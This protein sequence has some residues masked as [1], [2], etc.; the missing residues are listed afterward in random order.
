[1]KKNV[2]SVND[3]Y[4]SLNDEIVMVMEKVFWMNHDDD[5][6]ND[7]DDQLEIVQIFSKMMVHLSEI[8][9]EKV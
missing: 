9:Q 6:S 1:V 5:D 8:D 2:L 7:D 3:L 4:L